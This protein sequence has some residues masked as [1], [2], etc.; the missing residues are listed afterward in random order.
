[1]VEQVLLGVFL[2]I[3]GIF[4]GVGATLKYIE[5][6]QKKQMEKMQEQMGNMGMLGGD[7]E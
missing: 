3:L 6:Q 4:T 2:Y 5:H 7:D 1:M